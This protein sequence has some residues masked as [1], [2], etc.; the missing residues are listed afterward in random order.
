MKQIF[1]LLTVF[2]GIIGCCTVILVCFILFIYPNSNN[3]ISS[4]NNKSSLQNT[5][6]ISD[7]PDISN[8]IE[9]QQQTDNPEPNDII[10]ETQTDSET[11]KSGTYTIDDIEF[12]F[13]DSV[14]NDITGKWRISS[15]AS[16]KDITEYVVDYYNTFFSSDDEIHAIVNFSLNTT[17]SISVPYGGTL[18]VAIHEY[19][20]G[21]EHDASALF[22]GMLLAEY[23]IDLSTGEA[24]NILS[25]NEKSDNSMKLLEPENSSE[26]LLYTI[27]VEQGTSSTGFIADAPTQTEGTYNSSENNF[28]TYN[29]LE[30]QQT[31]D[32]FVLN[33]STFKFHWPTCNDVK[34]IAPENY[35]T[36]NLSISELE[37]QGY[38]TCGHCF[39]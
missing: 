36:S 33:T 27:P 32:M 2:L 17:T 34:K 3:N 26:T 7:T 25:N 38:S 31:S 23:F 39:R 14:I 4:K 11:V 19:V 1:N 30:Q 16:S 15:I 29:N 9:P 20:A 8:Q 13:S 37:S 24:E 35:S 6:Y 28:N 5:A 21:E 12:W 10:P 18:D 22:G